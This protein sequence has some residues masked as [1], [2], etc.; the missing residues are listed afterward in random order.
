MARLEI[1]YHTVYSL[2][3]DKIEEV[4]RPLNDF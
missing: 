2:F 4:P 3:S 1:L